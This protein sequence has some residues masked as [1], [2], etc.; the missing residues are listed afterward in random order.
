MIKMQAFLRN[1]N[2]QVGRYG[3]P[4]LRLHGVLAGAKE[5][6]DGQMLLDPFEEQFHLPALAIKVGDQLGLQTEVV[7]QKDQPLAGVVPDHNAA[8]CCG[9]VLAG[10]IGCQHPCLIAQHRC[11]PPDASNA[12]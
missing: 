6:L 12:A 4:Y 2:E 9:I 7:G 5:H 11:D 8:Q 10:L 1:G 3:D